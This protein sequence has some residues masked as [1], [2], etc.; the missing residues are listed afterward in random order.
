MTEADLA[1]SSLRT[2]AATQVAVDILCTSVLSFPSTFFAVAL[3]KVSRDFLRFGL[4]GFED[5]VCSLSFGKS[6]PALVRFGSLDLGFVEDGMF[7]ADLVHFGG[8][9]L[10]LSLG[11]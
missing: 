8:L 9:G 2:G 5:S 1:L 7:V 3:A 10:W 11:F 4:D 6:D